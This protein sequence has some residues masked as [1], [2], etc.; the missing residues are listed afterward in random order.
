MKAGSRLAALDPAALPAAAADAL[1][2]ELRRVHRHWLDGLALPGE[3]EVGREGLV[4]YH[5]G[6]VYA[7]LA[8]DRRD[9][10]RALIPAAG[11]SGAV[12]DRVA[13][14]GDAAVPGLLEMMDRDFDRAGALAALGRM[15]AM[16]DAGEIHLS[17]ESR[18]VILHRI[19]S[20][21]TGD[22]AADWF[23]VTR[24]VRATRDPAFLPFARRFE[25]KAEAARDIA[26][27]SARR[28]LQILETV[29]ANQSPA[30]L[31]RGT[32]R[33]LA[34]MC[35]DATSGPR[36]GA[37]QSI[38]HEFDT[39]LRHLVSGRTGPARNA[40]TAVI[41]RSDAALH[42]GALTGDEHAIVADGVR[43][44]LGRM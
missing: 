31:A 12:A 11:T 22:E 7:V 6:L 35:A 16:A 14:L 29:A 17:A 30:G 44:V 38:Q 15:W 27:G 37:C 26:L 36:R 42:A 5:A 3:E 18:G 13:R 24:A 28:T 32:Y 9:A 19:L 40:F 8:L 2:E 4:E 10:D 41:R 25:S 23:G 1:I 39:A 21:A 34:L 20:A 33:L 43:T